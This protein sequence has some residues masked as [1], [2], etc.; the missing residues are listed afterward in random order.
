MEEETMECMR[1]KVDMFN[2][3]F[4]TDVGGNAYLMNKKKGLL[5]SEKR[6]TVT[7]YVCPKCGCIELHADEPTKLR[8]D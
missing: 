2:A 5:E 1:C 6:S 4:K 7:C 8:L 3:K